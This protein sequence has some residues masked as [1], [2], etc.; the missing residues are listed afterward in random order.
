MTLGVPSASNRT[1]AG[2]R[3]RWTIPTR[4]TAPDGAGERDRQL[5]GRPGRH[6]RAGQP[7]G[8]RPAFEQLEREVRHA[9]GLAD[10]VDLD[11]VGMPEPRDGLGL[12]PEPREL[13]GL[14]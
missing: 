9:A 1:F 12:D 4:W 14:D 13:R 8:E 5:G 3:S 7:L 10:L 6:R 2:F 11:D